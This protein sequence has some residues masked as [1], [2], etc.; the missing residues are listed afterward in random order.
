MLYFTVSPASEFLGLLSRLLRPCQTS[1]FVRAPFSRF[2]EWPLFS[3]SPWSSLGT[4]AG[5]WLWS[6][7][8][9]PLPAPGV[10]VAAFTLAAASLSVHCVR[11]CPQGLETPP[12]TWTSTKTSVC[13]SLSK[14]LS[15]RGPQTT[16]TVSG[17]HGLSHDR[18]PSARPQHRARRV[19]GPGMGFH[20]S[21]QGTTVRGGCRVTVVGGRGPIRGWVPRASH[22]DHSSVARTPPL[23]L[24][25]DLLTPRRQ[26]YP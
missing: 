10:S 3:Q 23:I 25:G 18:S 6:F 8:D 26:C 17:S 14:A 24:P 20:S 4:T 12:G 16:A 11:V 13:R 5:G 21:H 9:V 22:R 2:F 19:L 1:R 7:G 15:P